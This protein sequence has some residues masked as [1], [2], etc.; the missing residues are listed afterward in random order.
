M[1]ATTSAILK[2][3]ETHL[4]AP[5]PAF[6][7]PK[8]AANLLG[9]STKTI[10]RWIAAGRLEHVKVDR[11]IRIPMSAIHEHRSRAAQ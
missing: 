1:D 2:A 7:S 5:Q 4:V 9:F 10:Y 8:Q 3:A 6:L 11:H